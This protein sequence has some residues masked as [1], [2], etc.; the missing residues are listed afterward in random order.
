MD[1]EAFWFRDGNI[2]QVDDGTGH[3]H[4]EF[5][6]THPNT[7]N[8]TKEY[9][10]KI[11]IKYNEPVGFEGNAREE[12][13]VKLFLDNWIRVRH[14]VGKSDYWIIQCANIK[15]QKQN[16]Q[17]L[18]QYLILDTN[19]MRE[20]DIVY[21]NDLDGAEICYNGWI[22]KANSFLSILDKNEKL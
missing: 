14:R 3:K 7:F 4:I 12:I 2:I 8:L 13:F 10:E 6:I 9:I 22:N 15:Q 16:L 21:I 11:Y 1:K 19:I 17:K 20:S 18:A 5:V